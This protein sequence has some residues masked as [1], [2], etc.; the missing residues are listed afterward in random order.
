MKYEFVTNHTQGPTES[1]S[2]GKSC[3]FGKKSIH[4]FTGTES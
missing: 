1:K 2:H 4:I 3:W